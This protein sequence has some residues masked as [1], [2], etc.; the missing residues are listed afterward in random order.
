MAQGRPLLTAA[1]LGP[2]GAVLLRAG[3]ER[4]ALG[5]P[6]L[7]RAAGGLAQGSGPM[8]CVTW[9]GSGGRPAVQVCAGLRHGRPWLGI[10]AWR[11]GG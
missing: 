7:L 6:C 5:L 2:A 1:L 4:L 10:D 8:S 11:S 3:A 9:E